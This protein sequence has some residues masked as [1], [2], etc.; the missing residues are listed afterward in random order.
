MKVELGDRVRDKVAG[1]EGIAVS[2]TR[3]LHGFLRWAVQP[4]TGEDEKKVDAEW[5]DDPNFEVIEKNVIRDTVPTDTPPRHGP[6]D[7]PKARIGS[8][9]SEGQR[10]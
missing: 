10:Q 7:D 8:S 6:R 4:R 1:V 5:V 2:Y 9:Q 3:W